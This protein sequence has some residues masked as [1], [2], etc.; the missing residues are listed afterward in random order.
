MQCTQIWKSTNVKLRG[1]LDF[2]FL[3]TVL[4]TNL[5]FSYKKQSNSPVLP[6]LWPCLAEQNRC[7]VLYINWKPFRRL[8]G[9]QNTLT[10]SSRAKH[11]WNHGTVRSLEVD[12]CFLSFRGSSIRSSID[13]LGHWMTSVVNRLWPLSQPSPA[14]W[15]SLQR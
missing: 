11:R 13:G 10:F 7:N 15:I 12:E 14:A 5:L 6:H 1:H 3:C 2:Y 9:E 8:S 4:I